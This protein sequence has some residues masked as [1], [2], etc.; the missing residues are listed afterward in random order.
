MTKNEQKMTKNENKIAIIVTHR[1]G[2]ARIADRIIVMKDGEIAECGSHE[3]LLNKNGVYANM[4]N[5]Q[6]KWYN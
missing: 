3:E 2:A 6:A 5:A 4:F 1:M